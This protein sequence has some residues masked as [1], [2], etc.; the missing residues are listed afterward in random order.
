[1]IKIP[2]IIKNIPFIVICDDDTKEIIE[3]YV[4][5]YLDPYSKYININIHDVLDD[6]IIQGMSELI[7]NW[8]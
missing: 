1:V 4:D 6:D 8:G 7:K 5:A 2:V 3:I